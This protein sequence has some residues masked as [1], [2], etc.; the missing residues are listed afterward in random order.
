MV[1]L[2]WYCSYF[3][4][5]QVSLELSNVFTNT[6]LTPS[7]DADYSILKEKLYCSSQYSK[8]M[9][10]N[11]NYSIKS[12]FLLFHKGSNVYFWPVTKHYRT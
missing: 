2:Q 12:L 11:R 7:F 3:F 4:H 6:T 10:E 8:N 1:T 5:S 9:S